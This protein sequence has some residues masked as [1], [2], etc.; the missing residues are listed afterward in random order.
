[1]SIEAL[2]QEF[3]MAAYMGAHY[4]AMAEKW[5]ETRRLDERVQKSVELKDE[6]V[7]NSQTLLTA[8]MVSGVRPRE[9][10][11][12][13]ERVGLHQNLVIEAL[14]EKQEELDAS[15]DRLDD[16]LGDAYELEGGHRVFKTEDG[17]SV[18]DEYGFELSADT[19]DPD[20][21][22]N[23]RPKAETYFEEV[24]RRNRIV[25]EQAELLDYQEK[26][27]AAQ[28]KLD[29]GTLSRDD[30]NELNDLLNTAPTAVRNRLPQDGPAY[31]APKP[32]ENDA[33]VEFSGLDVASP[34]LMDQKFR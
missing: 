3:D 25:Q 13:V 15:Q 19:I 1:M 29:Q 5:Q 8:I 16:M 32:R 14:Q 22:E 31:Q 21:I 34:G 17:L 20:E 10:H 23:W 18:F 30:Y 11:Q 26:L 27:D 2:Q 7:A 9:Y 6:A 28:N 12:L 33:S 4:R 24:E